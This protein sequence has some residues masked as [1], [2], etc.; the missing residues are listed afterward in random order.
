VRLRRNRRDVEGLA[1]ARQ[2]PGRISALH[3]IKTTVAA[4]SLPTAA[5]C[6]E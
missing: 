1:P 2:R 4:M 3:I 5:R 6:R